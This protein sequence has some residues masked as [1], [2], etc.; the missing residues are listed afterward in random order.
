M[1]TCRPACRLP[2]TDTPVMSSASPVEPRQLGP[3]E[4]EVA[5]DAAAGQP[6]LAVAAQP[7][8]VAGAAD[9][10]PVGDQRRRAPAV[11]PPARQPQRAADLRVLQVHRPVGHEAVVE[12][13]VRGDPQVPGLQPGHPAPGEREPGELGHPQVRCRG[14][15]AV[16]QL[17]RPLDPRSDEREPPGHRGPAQA[18]R[19]AGRGERRG[20]RIAR[21][22]R[23]SRGRPPDRPPAPRRGRP[24]RSAGRGRRRSPAGVFTSGAGRRRGAQCGP[25]T[26]ASI[27]AS[28]AGVRWPRPSG[29]AHGPAPD[30]TGTPAGCAS[31]ADSVDSTG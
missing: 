6:Q 30:V 18:Q 21:A 5:G 15:G 28:V 11:Q 14:E 20:Q 2:P 4:V 31:A 19:T 8:R 3:G 29:E 7:A 26:L 22:A 12:Q 17:H 27:T 1:P 23:P 10:D 9:D 13:Q 24:P 16:E 25:R